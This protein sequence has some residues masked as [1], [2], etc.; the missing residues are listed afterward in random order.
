[1]LFDTLFT[2]GVSQATQL[3]SIHPPQLGPRRDCLH[4]TFISTS[5]AGT[6]RQVQFEQ[7][8]RAWPVLKQ[9]PN[10]CH[11]HRVSYGCLSLELQ[12]RDDQDWRFRL[13]RQQECKQIMCL[14]FLSDVN[15][16]NCFSKSNSNAIQILCSSLLEIHSTSVHVT[17]SS[18]TCHLESSSSLLLLSLSFHIMIMRSCYAT[19][20]KRRSRNPS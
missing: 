10:K 17:L 8:S 4:K 15:L 6:R 12:R 19:T 11:R 7:P 3:P 9:R 20:T 1:M 5:R 18:S 16:W 2:Q 13:R 14:M